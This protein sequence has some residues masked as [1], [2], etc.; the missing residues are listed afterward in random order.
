LIDV[1]APSPIPRT[2][3]RGRS[4]I[5]AALRAAAPPVAAAEQIAEA[6]HVPEMSAKSP[7]SRRPTDRIRRR[8]PSRS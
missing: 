7:N 2:Q 6:E 8:R 4:Q 3:S 1:S 5:G